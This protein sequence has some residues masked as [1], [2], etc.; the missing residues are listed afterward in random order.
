MWYHWGGAATALLLILCQEVDDDHVAAATPRAQAIRPVRRGFRELLRAT[1]ANR[2]RGDPDRQRSAP[3][4]PRGAQPGDDLPLSLTRKA[5]AGT[6]A[7]VDQREGRAVALSFSCAAR[8]SMARP[9][10][11]WRRRWWYGG[12]G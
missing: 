10:P 5:R 9:A 12:G 1:G 2:R 11:P 6:R 3:G 4:P 8:F 7:L